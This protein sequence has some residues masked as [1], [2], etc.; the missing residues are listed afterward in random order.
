MRLRVAVIAATG[1]SNAALAAKAATST[2]PIVFIG[3]DPVK[4]SIVASLSRPG[5]NITG[6]ALLTEVLG[7]KRLELVHEL[8]PKAAV[9][10]LLIN[11]GSRFAED[12]EKDAQA[13]A[14]ASGLR[15]HVARASR[16]EEFDRAFETLVHQHADALVVGNDPF[17]L[18]RRDRLVALA[19]RHAIPAIYEWRD[20]AAAG[21]LM[22][23]GTS[24]ASMYRQAGVYTGQIL[25]GAKPAN[26]PV[27]QPTKFELVVNLRTAK[28]LGLAIPPSILVRADEVIE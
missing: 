26:L 1:G 17:F 6:I 10:G 28:G 18:S 14:R 25:R 7:P 4:M 21:G 12:I 15:L 20:F 24:L 27:L 19:A 8:I 5:G 9:I 11:P 13:A 3:G 16:E 22:S 23:Y 2:I